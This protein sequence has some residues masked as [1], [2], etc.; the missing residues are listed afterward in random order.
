[1][2][3]LPSDYSSSNHSLP[4][5]PRNSFDS[6]ILLEKPEDKTFSSKILSFFC[7]FRDRSDE[8]M[9]VLLIFNLILNIICY[10][11]FLL[12]LYE[13]KLSY[14]TYALYISLFLAVNSVFS[15]CF[16]FDWV[17][18]MLNFKTLDSLENYNYFYFFIDFVSGPL[19][20]MLNIKI[21]VVFGMFEYYCQFFLLNFRLF[22]A[23]PIRGILIKIYQILP[24]ITP[25]LLYLFVFAY[26]FSSFAIV[27]FSETYPEDWGN[28]PKALFSIFQ[29]MTLDN[30]GRGGLMYDTNDSWNGMIII[31]FNFLF[32]FCFLNYF[33]GC[34]VDYLGF[35]DQIL[36][37]IQEINDGKLEKQENFWKN[38]VWGSY[39]G[40]VMKGVLILI[41]VKDCLYQEDL[42]DHE[43]NLI[44]CLSIFGGYSCHFLIYII[45]LNKESK[46]QDK[47]IEKMITIFN[48]ISGPCGMLIFTL[49]FVNKKNTIQ[50]LNSFLLLKMFTITPLKYILFDNIRVISLLFTFYLFIFVVVF[51]IGMLLTSY[52][53]LSVPSLFGSWGKGFYTVME[54]IT[55][56]GWASSILVKIQK[57]IYLAP[58]IEIVLIIT[59]HFLLIN[60]VN[61]LSCNEMNM[62]YMMRTGVRIAKYSNDLSSNNKIV[63]LKRDVEEFIR[64]SLAISGIYE[65]FVRRFAQKRNEKLLR[66]L[67]QKLILTDPEDI[68][69]FYL[70]RKAIYN[71]ENNLGFH[72]SFLRNKY[73]DK[74]VRILTLS[75]RNKN[76]ANI[77]EGDLRHA[78]KSDNNLN[79][80]NNNVMKPVKSCESF[81]SSFDW[82]FSEGD[83]CE[84]IFKGKRIRLRNWN[85]LRINNNVRIE[86]KEEDLQLQMRIRTRIGSL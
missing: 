21:L 9:L 55:L 10:E 6:V 45:G 3:F 62:I 16:S 12:L 57:Y 77:F 15:L 32:N 26:M 4:G 54:M 83:G 8:I 42:I 53:S 28:Y 69:N 80:S 49:I 78:N 46:E 50:Y 20:L 14:D 74:S 64:K 41:L 30:W 81:E 27:L 29:V 38:L 75:K 13:S 71:S 36:K 79:S 72:L 25:F 40:V 23:K 31:A 86:C 44:I 52:L 84:L 58:I 66:L 47:A 60:I 65:N 33:T 11:S 5:T 22:S 48:F 24:L 68:Q 73:V 85:F 2:N 18:K 59:I 56:D 76:R 7:D 63:V 17:A 19:A 82:V 37:Q 34:I 39:Y 35:S 43:T 67:D 1:M 70:I 51:L 61:A